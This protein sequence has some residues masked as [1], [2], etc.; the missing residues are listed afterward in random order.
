MHRIPPEP[1]L[2]AERLS[3]ACN[4]YL[5]EEKGGPCQRCSCWEMKEGSL[6]VQDSE[7]L[8]YVRGLEDLALGFIALMQQN[9][10]L[11]S[12]SLTSI[13]PASS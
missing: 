3:Q 1:G 10:L 5:S 2:S 13:K 4:W 9:D 12:D 7:V 11:P 8:L 6:E